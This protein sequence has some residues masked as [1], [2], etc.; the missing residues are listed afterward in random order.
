MNQQV[1]HVLGRATQDG[2]L[3]E[4][5]AG[6]EYSKFSIAVNEFRGEE[7]GES[8]TFIDVVGFNKQTK[9]ATQKIKSGDII[10]ASGRPE[11]QAYMSKDGE[12]KAKL[13]MQAQ[14]IY[15]YTTPEKQ[16]EEQSEEN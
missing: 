10:W 12:L 5:K 6:K 7:K 14:Y 11:A 1:L 13:S 2:Q 9:T 8:T 3:L 15:A 4:S 16:T